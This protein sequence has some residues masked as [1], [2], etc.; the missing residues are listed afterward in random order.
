MRNSST[1]QTGAMPHG[2]GR[3]ARASFA[4]QCEAVFCSTWDGIW[5]EQARGHGVLGLSQRRLDGGL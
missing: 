5:H 1:Q 4:A 2:T 3:G